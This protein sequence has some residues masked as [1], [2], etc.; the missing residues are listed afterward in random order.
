MIVVLFV[1]SYLI[2]LVLLRRLMLLIY[3][4]VPLW[5][6]ETAI[7]AGHIRISML[8]LRSRLSRLTA[9]FHHSFVV[10]IELELVKEHISL[11]RKDSFSSALK[12][13]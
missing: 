1:V 8:L 2:F 3:L 6:D 7:G 5:Y 11:L 4:C 12:H 10:Q 13:E 9:F